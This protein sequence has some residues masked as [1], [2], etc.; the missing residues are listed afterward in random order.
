MRNSKDV[1]LSNQRI[2]LFDIDKTMLDTRKMG[3]KYD[4]MI[5]EITGM[6]LQ[7]IREGMDCYISGLP[8][9]TYFDFENWI[10]VYALS[11]EQK[12]RIM[13]EYAN[14]SSLYV[15][16]DDVDEA[17]ARLKADGYRIGIFSEGVDRYQRNKLRNLQIGEYIDP[18]LVFIAQS[19]RLDE[20]LDAL[21]EGCTIVDDNIE[22]VSIIVKHGKHKAVFLNRNGIE[23]GLEG[24]NEI[25]S[26]DEF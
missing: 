23:H 24:I 17:L 26:L 10:D 8:N 20:Y 7:V 3:E 2:I 6:T 22:V 21:P 11:P 13:E 15:K 9:I 25:R 14:N 12:A 5:L 4:A 18:D 19:K 16:Y 1:I